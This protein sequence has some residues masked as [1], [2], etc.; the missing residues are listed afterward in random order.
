M[1][2]QRNSQNTIYKEKLVCKNC[3]SKF[4]D[5]LQCQVIRVYS[6]YPNSGRII[7]YKIRA[8]RATNI[9]RTNQTLNCVCGH[10]VGIVNNY[11]NLNFRFYLNPNFVTK[12]VTIYMP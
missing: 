12:A 9:I 8:N 5:D 1:P 7:G 3:R 4:I 6:Y 11:R 2:R 10:F